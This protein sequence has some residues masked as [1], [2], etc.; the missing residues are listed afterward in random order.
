[1]TTN[2]GQV[3]IGTGEVG[4]IPPKRYVSTPLGYA[5]SQDPFATVSSQYGT[6]FIDAEVGRVFLFKGQGGINEI[7]NAGMEH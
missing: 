3:S 1:M 6:F 4:S 5:G 2:E 7:S